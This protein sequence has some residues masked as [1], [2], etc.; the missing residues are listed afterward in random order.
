MARP[1]C[2]RLLTQRHAPRRLSG[3][4][5]GGEQEGDQDGDDAD[6][7]QELDQREARG[8]PSDSRAHGLA[9]PLAVRMRVKAVRFAVAI[10]WGSI[11]GRWSEAAVTRA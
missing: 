3:G 11:E 9:S 5:D 8:V 2:F 7:D 6:D 4:L 10:A 1:S